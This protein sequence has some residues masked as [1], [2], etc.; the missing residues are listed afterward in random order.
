MSRLF[1][2]NPKHSRKGLQL[3]ITGSIGRDRSISRQANVVSISALP[4]SFLLPMHSDM[5]TFMKS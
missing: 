2:S 3:I 1:R 4:T 5:V